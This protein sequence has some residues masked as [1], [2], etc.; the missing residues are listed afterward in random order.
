MYIQIT[1]VPRQDA[2]ILS[3]YMIQL[4]RESSFTAHALTLAR[5]H[6]RT[7]S[8]HTH[9]LTHAR[10]Y[11]NTHTQTARNYHVTT[12]IYSIIEYRTQ[13][14]R[15]TSRNLIWNLLFTIEP[16]KICNFRSGFHRADVPIFF[17]F[18]FASL[19][20]YRRTTVTKLRVAF[21]LKK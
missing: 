21:V 7:Y 14:I 15:C 13:K 19:T 5:V 2:L 8:R 4:R 1:C 9:N 11:T 17:H 12:E 18:P 6:H 20:R 16:R 10:I 3:R